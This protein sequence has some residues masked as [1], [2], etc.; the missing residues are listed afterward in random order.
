MDQFRWHQLWRRCTERNR[1]HTEDINGTFFS[2]LLLSPIPFDAKYGVI[3]EPITFDIERGMIVGCKTVH[4]ELLKDLEYY[5]QH[6][7][8]YGKIEKLVSVLM[9]VCQ[10]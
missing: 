1:P 8:T 2:C 9:K 6:A 3:H 10:H 7:K 4:S 5:F